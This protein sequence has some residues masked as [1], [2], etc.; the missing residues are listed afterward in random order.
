MYVLAAYAQQRDSS[1][2]RRVLIVDEPEPP[3]SP[4]STVLARAGYLAD[5]CS[6]RRAAFDVLAGVEHGVLIA[7][8]H[9]D[10]HDGVALVRQVQGAHVDVS[11]ILLNADDTLDDAVTVLR[12]GVFDFM[13]KVFSLS[14][15]PNLLLHALR[16]AFLGPVGPAAPLWTNSTEGVLDPLQDNGVSPGDM[17][18]ESGVRLRVQSLLDMELS[19]ML[20][21]LDL[22]GGNKA[23]AARLLGVDRTTLY[24]KLQRQEQLKPAPTSDEPGIAGQRK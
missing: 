22:V 2:R 9:R 8:Q 19:Y 15:S 18:A 1:A 14:A 5:H 11:V 7:E 23:S 16:R 10:L 13:T 21:V 12:T 17:P 3:R 24:R 6:D 4:L 20:Q